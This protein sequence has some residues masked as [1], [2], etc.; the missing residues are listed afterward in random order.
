M[1]YQAIDSSLFTE[2]RKRFRKLMQPGSVAFFHANDQMPYSGDQ[3]FPYRQ[4]PDF[5]YLTGIDQ[6]KSILMLYPDSPNPAL[7]EVLFLL[8]TNE[9]IAIWE[10][11]KYTKEEATAASGIGSVLWLPS[12]EM[13]MKEAMM[14]ATNVYLGTIEN[15]RYSGEMN[16]RNLRFVSDLKARYPLHQYLR[17]TP[18]ITGLR[19]IKS[20]PELT[21]MQKGHRYHHRSVS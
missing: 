16:D 12:F 11:H 5:F 7:R 21:L 13:M 9:H 2:N 4:N 3:Y 19:L 20:E 18:L 1:K 8:E 17:A 10:G 14:Y 6:E 15:F